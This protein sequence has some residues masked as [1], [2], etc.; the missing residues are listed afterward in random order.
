MA[1]Q[2]SAIVSR[3][4]RLL[5]DPSQADLPYRDVLDVVQDVAGGRY[6]D[7]RMTGR[8]HA[9]VIGAW[10]TPTDREMNAAAFAGGNPS[11]I[12]VRMEWLALG[13]DP[14]ITAPRPVQLVGLANLNDL[15]RTSQSDTYAAF[16]NGMESI[17]FSELPEILYQ[18]Q[19]RLTYEP[20]GAVSLEITGEANLPSEFVTLCAYETAFLCLDHVAN[21]SEKWI[22]KRERLRVTLATET[23]RWDERFRKWQTGRF[24]NKVVQK[25]GYRR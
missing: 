22:D 15:F 23:A 17:A 11:F 1:I 9:S 5:G 20:T 4:Y 8:D 7:L 19:Y 3:V 12:P 14:A 13:D 18:R 21:E 25:V 10:V 2:A 6:L 24:G 16:Y